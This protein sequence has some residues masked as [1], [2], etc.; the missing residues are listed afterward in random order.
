MEAGVRRVSGGVGVHL[1]GK[2][3]LESG[4]AEWSGDWGRFWFWVDKSRESE[5]GER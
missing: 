3:K 2:G 5:R 4:V 1:V